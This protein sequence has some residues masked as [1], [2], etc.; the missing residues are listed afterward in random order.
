MRIQN[1]RLRSI[2]AVA[3]AAGSL[4]VV[5]A[6]CGG[7]ESAESAGTT[8]AASTPEL[9]A[10]G[11]APVARL[12]RSIEANPDIP[13]TT[14][15]AV[16]LT[17]A[18]LY[19]VSREAAYNAKSFLAGAEV[20]V[21]GETL[22]TLSYA[23]NGG[24]GNT[25]LTSGSARLEVRLIGST[26]YIKGSPRVL[27]NLGISSS[28]GAEIPS[29]QWFSVAASEVG[30]LTKIVSFEGILDDFLPPAAPEGISVSGTGELAGFPVV[31][32]DDA[33]EGVTVAVAT[34]GPPY[35]ILVSSTP[36]GTRSGRIV[37]TAWDATLAIPE[38]SNAEPLGVSGPDGG[39]G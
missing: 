2:A 36:S 29:D 11:S 13:T 15:E 35:P 4:G 37:F 21:N 9:T 5:A 24:V 8:A 30:E 39:A 6:G 38:P 33:S 16:S 7:S 28:S 27:A 32:L 31:N 22:S 18:E 23:E 19:S 25:V 1:T 26:M 3:L 20:T 34:A 17:A 10:D 14:N 12:S